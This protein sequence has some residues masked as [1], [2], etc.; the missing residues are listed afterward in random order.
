[1]N[2]ILWI[3]TETTGKDSASNSIIELGLI[4]EID[5]EIK[6]KFKETCR[7]LPMAIIDQ[8]ALDIQKR[9]MEEITK[10]QDPKE[11]YAKTCKFLGSFVNKFDKDDKLIPAGYNVNFDLVVFQIIS[12]ICLLLSF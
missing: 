3:D 8:D 5:G 1:M 4:V 6:G 7:P 12:K 2:K 10:F 9:T 11:L